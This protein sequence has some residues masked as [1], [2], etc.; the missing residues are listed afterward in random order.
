[1]RQRLYWTRLR[2]RVRNCIHALLARQHDLELP[3]CADLFGR[4]GLGFLRGLQ[5]KSAIDQQLL[6]EDLDLLG[7]LAVQ[8]K[9]QEERIQKANALDAVPS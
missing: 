8:I 2:T 3:Q 7:L 9:G 1:M 4:R 6:A 5:L